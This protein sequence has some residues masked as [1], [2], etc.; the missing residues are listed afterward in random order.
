VKRLSLLLLFPLLLACANLETN[1]YRTIG[2]F[3]T[4]VEAAR[5][6]F[7]GYENECRCVTQS[8]HDQV[9]ALYLKYQAAMKLAQDAVVIY[10]AS[11]APNA[12]AMNIALNAATTAATDIILAIEAFLPAPQAERVKTQ[13]GV[14]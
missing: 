14:K 5:Q 2:T 12:D 9:Q 8:Q 11:T 1:A 13:T 3:T 4:G 10:K 6:A 7:V